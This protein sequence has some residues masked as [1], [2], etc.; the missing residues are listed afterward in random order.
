MYDRFHNSKENGLSKIFFPLNSND[1]HGYNSESLWAKKAGDNYYL[2]M[3]VPFYIKNLSLYDT[4][5]AKKNDGKLIFSSII[6]RGGH[7]TYRIVLNNLVNNNLFAKY[8]EPLEEKGCTY[9]KATANLYSID[10]PPSSD[11]YNVYSLLVKGEN[12]SVW[13]FEEGY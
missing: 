10:V 9:E 11:I 2:V 4:V 8:W 6:T 1:W 5:N 7:S 3:N 12:D 13:E